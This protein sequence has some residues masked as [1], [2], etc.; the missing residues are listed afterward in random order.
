MEMKALRAQMNPHFIFNVLNSIHY[1]ITHNDNEKAQYYLT[2][3]AKLIRMTLDNSR[4]TFISLA[5]ELSLL[6]LYIDLEKIRFEGRF[7]YEIKV[8]EDIAPNAIKIPN[9]LIQPYVENSIKHGFKTEKSNAFVCINIS[10]SNEKVN[11]TIED[12]G[13]GRKKAASLISNLEKEQ[14]S[15]SGTSIVNDKIGA[16]KMYYNYD[17]SSQTIDLVDE[18]G[19]SLGTRVIISFPVKFE[20]T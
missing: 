2:K 16:L 6:Q 20:I 9:M 14:H 13:I 10:R 3:F 8:A 17:M 1:Y 18:N 19:N 4:T 11:C 12:N 5:D 7:E 15:S